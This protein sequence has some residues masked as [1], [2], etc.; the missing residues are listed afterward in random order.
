V[1]STFLLA[2]ST[3]SSS[4]SIP[5]YV[6]VSPGLEDE[7]EVFTSKVW[8]TLNDPKGWSRLSGFCPARREEASIRVVLADPANVQELCHPIATYGQ[9]SCALGD[10]AVINLKP[11]SSPPA[12][13]RMFPDEYRTY[14]INHEVGHLLG[15]P[16][17][18]HCTSSGR[19]P[20]MMQQSRRRPR[21]LVVGSTPT[22]W[23]LSR[24]EALGVVNDLV[25]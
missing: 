15:M 18:N 1:I 4:G 14:V 16:H 10:T 19:A 22:W 2:L 7:L 21:C 9:V 8:T 23:E 12:S 5:T 20:L 17:A 13:W 6:G 25:R 24:V 11:W 3:C